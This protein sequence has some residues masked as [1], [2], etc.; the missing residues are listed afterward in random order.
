[1]NPSKQCTGNTIC[2][3]SSGR[4][5]CASGYIQSG[6]SCIQATGVLFSF[7][8]CCINGFCFDD[9]YR[10]CTVHECDC[11]RP[12]YFLQP[13]PGQILSVITQ[14]Y[15]FDFPICFIFWWMCCYF[16]IDHIQT[17]LKTFSLQLLCFM[18]CFV[19]LFSMI[20]I[21][22]TLFICCISCLTFSYTAGLGQSC[23]SPTKTCT[24]SH[25]VCNSN[26]GTCICATG[27]TQ[28]GSVCVVGSDPGLLAIIS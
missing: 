14:H 27:Y 9:F 17:E 12:N 26:S 25:T 10:E 2:S 21:I 22:L 1:M 15:C 8:W 19:L 4:C 18:L 5:V 3:G 28:S 13:C 24:V 7:L 11:F 16:I 6:T 20:R 23:L